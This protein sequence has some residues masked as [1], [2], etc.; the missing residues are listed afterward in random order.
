MRNKGDKA[1]KR[2]GNERLGWVN[3]R[4]GWVRNK[5]TGLKFYRAR[6]NEEY[7]GEI[8]YVK[9]LQEQQEKKE[10]TA[11]P[12]RPNKRKKL[13]SATVGSDSNSGGSE[14]GFEPKPKSAKS[15]K[16]LKTRHSSFSS[17]P[18]SSPSPSSSSSSSSPSSASPSC[19]KSLIKKCDDFIQ[20]SALNSS[21]QVGN[22][23]SHFAA[24]GKKTH[25]ESKLLSSVAASLSDNPKCDRTLVAEVNSTYTGTDKQQRSNVFILRLSLALSLSLSLSFFSLFS[26]T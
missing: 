10:E 7:T 23:S 13:S 17:S 24:I 15:G 4:L 25:V 21:S 11:F 18:S 5:N 8:A 3:K 22:D 14:I 2:L 19:S 20:K 6:D 1:N 16:R 12:A 26:C 9:Y